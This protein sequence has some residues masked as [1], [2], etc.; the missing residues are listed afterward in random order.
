M[1]ELFV[2]DHFRLQQGGMPLA[3]QFKIGA[4]A[5]QFDAHGQIGIARFRALIEHRPVVAEAVMGMI[6]LLYT[7][8]SPRDS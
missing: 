4:V 2:Y 7:S 5:D 1:F 3:E 8:P 6:C